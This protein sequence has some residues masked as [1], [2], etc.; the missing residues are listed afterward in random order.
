PV[1]VRA[2]HALARPQ[3]VAGRP[4]QPELMRRARAPALLALLVLAACAAPPPVEDALALESVRFADLAGW[5]DDDHA[6]A[7]DTFKRGCAIWAKRDASDALGRNGDFGVVGDWRTACVAAN[8]VP[9]GHPAAARAY[10]ETWFQPW[11]AT[12]N[13]VADGLFTGYFEPVLDGSRAASQRFAVP[14]YGRPEDLVTVDLGQFA[15]DLAGRS[16]AGRVEAGALQPYPDRAAIAD[17]AVDGTA[18]VLA[19]VDDAIDAFFLEIQGSG[20]VRLAEGGVMR[21]GYAAQNGRRYF[22]IGKALVERG[23]LTKDEVSLQT[24]KAWLAQHPDEARAVM[25]LNP[26]A[27]FFREL[28][29]EGPVG[30]MGVVLTPA[31]SLAVDR[32]FIALG[33]PLWLEVTVPGPAE[34]A[35]DETWRRLV[36][37][38]D[39]GGA[40]KGPVRGD[41]YWGGGAEAEWR[42]GTMKH[43]GG[44]YVLLP[45]MLTV[46]S[47]P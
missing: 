1:D 10:F 28:D 9:P 21:V 24:I 31:R 34:G 38:Q 25:N 18:P 37:A 40:I 22:A 2:R 15:E 17:G 41:L 11:R 13:G 20:Q 5:A 4:P 16:I 12:N 29:G 19:W 36:I 33:V 27:V 42:A 35:P 44:Y 45:T 39:T 6:S 23:A 26:S 8:D 46:A 7:L 14:L 3:L 43:T 47:A 30:A 32:R